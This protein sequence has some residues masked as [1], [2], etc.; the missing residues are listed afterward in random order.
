MKQHETNDI[1]ET[2]MHI[3]PAKLLPYKKIIQQCAYPPHGKEW[4]PGIA[5]DAI[6]AFA[7]NGGAKEYQ[8][9]LLVFFLE[10]GIGFINDYEVYEEAS[11]MLLEDIF[12]TTL[13]TLAKEDKSIVDRYVPRMKALLDS[14][15]EWSGL[16][17]QLADNWQEAF[18][19]KK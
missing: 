14:A 7:K 5:K 16:H 10:C 11:N 13:K 3:G 15:T 12:E 19:E 17:D 9:E 2:S 4:E 8:F 6:D 1:I 18:G